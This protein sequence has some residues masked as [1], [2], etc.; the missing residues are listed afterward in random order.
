MGVPLTVE[1]IVIIGREVEKLVFNMYGVRGPLAVKAREMA[2]KLA[3]A[4]ANDN[5]ALV[6][7]IKDFYLATGVPQELIEKVDEKV[8]QIL[9]LEKPET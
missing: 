1:H 9:G 7:A 2:R 4:Y 6:R 3:N 8:R 5:K